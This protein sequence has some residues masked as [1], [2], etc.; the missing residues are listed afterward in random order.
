ECEAAAREWGGRLAVGRKK[1]SSDESEGACAGKSS[2][3][4][5]PVANVMWPAPVFANQADNS[6][7]P[8][9]A[10]DSD[11]WRTAP[12]FPQSVPG[13]PAGPNCA[14]DRQEIHSPWERES[15]FH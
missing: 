5:N 6:G 3:G 10:Y 14:V 11:R 12:G 8:G 13:V 4:T 2:G 7:S 9:Y 15:G 1:R